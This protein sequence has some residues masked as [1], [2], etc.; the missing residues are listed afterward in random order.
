MSDINTVVLTGRLGRDPELRFFESGS[1]VCSFSIAVNQW[2]KK[3]E[4]EIAHWFDVQVWGKRGEALANYCRKGSKV[5]V[6]GRLEQN[7]WQ[8]KD[9]N[10]RSS[11]RVS[12]AQVDFTVN[13]DEQSQS[14]TAQGHPLESQQPPQQTYSQPAPQGAPVAAGGPDDYDYIPF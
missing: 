12:A 3:T 9:G 4:K 13:R 10:K 5:T 6:Q 14:N 1:S 8:D 2:D 11:V 7:T